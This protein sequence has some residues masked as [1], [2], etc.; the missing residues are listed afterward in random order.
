MKKLKV[1]FAGSPAFVFPVVEF[2]ARE[3]DLQAV[4]TNAPAKTGRGK[5]LLPSPLLACV[6]EFL[7][8]DKS[9]EVLAK[10]EILEVENIDDE[11]IQKVKKQG[12]DLLVCYAFGKFFPQE[13]LALFRYGGINIHPSLLPRWRGASPVPS[14]ILAGDKITG[15]SIQTLAKKMDT[16]KILARTEYALDDTKNAGEVLQVLTENAIPL[17]RVVLADIEKA[18]AEAQEQNEVEACYCTKIT[19]EKIDW[20]KSALEIAREVLALSPNPKAFSEVAGERITLLEAKA[21]DCADLLD[22]KV[23]EY[24]CGEALNSLEKKQK[25]GKIVGTD[26]K[27]GILV[28]TGN[29]ILAIQKLQRQGKKELPW[30]DFLNGYKNFLGLSFE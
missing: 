6:R 25:I 5:K 30:K 15:V 13:F 28:Q 27:N 24:V 29:G 16:G 22:C 11:V 12:C 26:K 23:P 4:M 21:L 1:I 9:C 3:S 7:Q 10:A 14:A 2:L 19:R 8:S 17:L 18:L 20:R